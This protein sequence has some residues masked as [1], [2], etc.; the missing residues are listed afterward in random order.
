M[1]TSEIVVGGVYS[2]G[3]GRRRTV[4]SITK[5]RE[6]YVVPGFESETRY[7]D[8]DNQT[9]CCYTKNFARWAKERIA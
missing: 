5:L 7:L 2:N 1:K 3:N 8:K 9:F 4:T 6:G